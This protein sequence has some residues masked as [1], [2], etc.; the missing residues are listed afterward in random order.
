LSALD[1]CA[2]ASSLLPELAAGSS[3]LTLV[4]SSSRPKKNPDSVWPTAAVVG[5]Q[6]KLFG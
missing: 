5:E 4:H 1:E 3:G 2:I 6:M